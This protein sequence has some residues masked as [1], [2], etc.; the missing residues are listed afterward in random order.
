MN[1]TTR[2]LGGSLGIAIFGSL[3]ASRYVSQLSPNLAGLPAE[4]R[5]VAEGSLPGALGVASKLGPAGQAL[6]TA[7]RESWMS[8]FRFSLVVGV[9]VLALAGLIAFRFLPDQAAD[10]VD[11]EGE[12]VDDEGDATEVTGSPASGTVA[13]TGLDAEP[14]QA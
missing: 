3:L 11:D 4:A 1:D 13:V 2:E 6:L 14:A 8:G 12:M 9:V 10:A 5:E 7:A